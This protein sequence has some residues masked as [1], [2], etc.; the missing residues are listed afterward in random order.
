MQRKQTNYLFE[1]EDPKVIPEDVKQEILKRYGLEGKG[2]KQ[3]K[4]RTQPKNKS[5][6]PHITEFDINPYVGAGVLY[7]GMTSEQFQQ[8][9]DFHPRK[10][11][12]HKEVIESENFSVCFVY[13]KEPG[14]CEAI[15]FT[16]PATVRFQGKNL[17]EEPYAEIRDFVKEHDPDLECDLDGFTSCKFGFGVYASVACIDPMEPIEAVIVFEKGYYDRETL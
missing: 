1:M 9:L 5:Q 17:I 3:P 13:Y 4:N 15:E 6:Y 8:T 10:F 16:S 14:I 7:L 2:T 12:R 11:R